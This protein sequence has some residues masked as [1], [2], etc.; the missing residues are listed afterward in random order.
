MKEEAADRLWDEYKYRHQHCWNTVFK[1][2]LAVV[3]ISVLPYT[4]V[5]V[6]CALGERQI[7]LLPVLAVSLGLFCSVVMHRE[8]RVLDRIRAAHRAEQKTTDLGGDWFRPLVIA[9]LIAVSVLA[10]LNVLVV[11]AW[12]A[13]IKKS[14]KPCFDSSRTS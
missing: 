14:A 13:E 3:A 10:G 9:Y 11:R 5:S 6:V 8:L 12:Q 2:T 7:S 4:Q 1:L